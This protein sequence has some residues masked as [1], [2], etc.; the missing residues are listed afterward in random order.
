MGKTE[1]RGEEKRLI[2]TVSRI[3]GHAHR[4][5]RELR[6]DRCLIRESLLICRVVARWVGTG[7]T[8]GCHPGIPRVGSRVEEM[9]PAN[10]RLQAG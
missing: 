3:R 4:L 8:P 7:T 2:L 6:H 1:G 10:D 5:D 9:E